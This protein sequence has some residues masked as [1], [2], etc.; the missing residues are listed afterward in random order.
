[1]PRAVAIPPPY[2]LAPDYVYARLA[3]D[4]VERAAL[5]L[6]PGSSPSSSYSHF[7]TRMSSMPTTVDRMLS[8][9]SVTTNATT[10]GLPTSP[11]IAP[12]WMPVSR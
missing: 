7:A 10:A 5:V 11:L 1:M 8:P 12:A 4:A 2:A 6:R 3:D 9:T